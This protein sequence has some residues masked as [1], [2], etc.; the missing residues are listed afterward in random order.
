MSLQHVSLCGFSLSLAPL[1]EP[2]HTEG[3][4]F[5]NP[6]LPF[7]PNLFDMNT[8]FEASNAEHIISRI[9]KLQSTARSQWGKMSVAQ[10]LAHCQQPFGAFFGEYKMK[11]GLIGILFGKMA[12]RKLFSDKPWPQNL[13]TAHEFKIIHEKDFEKEKLALLQMISR[14]ITEGKNSAQNKHPFFGMMTTDE[15]GVLNYRHLD[16]HLLHF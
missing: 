11:R 5:P 3:V 7:P 15:W 13:P 1:R 8:L 2:K 9:Q 6:S 16:H 14:F 10:M 4:F 12:K